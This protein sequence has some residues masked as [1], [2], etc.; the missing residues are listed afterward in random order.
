MKISKLE[1]EVETLIM[2]YAH[3]ASDEDARSSRVTADKIVKLV[4]ETLEG[5]R[6]PQDSKPWEVLGMNS[7]K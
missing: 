3:P 4:K 6:E 1:I 2:K 5:K 7:I